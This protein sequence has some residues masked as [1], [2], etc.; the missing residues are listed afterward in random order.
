MPRRAGMRVVAGA[1]V[2]SGLALFAWRARFPSD[3]RQ[4]R[5]QLTQLAAR[6]NEHAQGLSAI[7]QAADVGAAFADDVV[8]DL[9]EGAPIR[10]RQMLM[11]IVA[12]V[13]PRTSR[14]QVTIRDI[15]VHVEDED[16]AAV[17]LSVTT[18]GESG[19]DAREF[20]LQMIKRDGT[21]LIARVAPVRVL[22]K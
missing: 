10:G 14:Y 13:Q 16:S 21:W 15:V 9:G 6:I 8:I 11:G 17:D 22:E 2:L 18:S 5:R 12:R 1:L 7:A 19:L 20:K 4:I 3:E